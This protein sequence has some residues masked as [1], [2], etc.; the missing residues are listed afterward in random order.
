[1]LKLFIEFIPLIA[2]FVGYK[3]DG[4][5]TATLYTLIATVGSTVITLLLRQKVSKVHLI[6]NTLLLVS[7]SLTLFSGNTTFIKMKPTIL[8][9]IFGF[10]FFI[11][12][13]KWEPAIKIAL[14]NA[15]QLEND[16]YWL[17]LNIRF[18]WLFFTMAAV[19]EFVWRTFP[20]ETWVNFKVFGALPATI[21][22]LAFQIPYLIKHKAPDLP[23]TPKT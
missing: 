14:G 3:V 5:F 9:C 10:A 13:F 17:Q 4:I 22:F 12:N 21:L 16:I 18:M 6:T 7:A 15:I 23:E 20:E 8:Y 11:T 1:M 2:F 19:N